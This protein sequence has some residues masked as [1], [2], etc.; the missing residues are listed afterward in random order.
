MG[1]IH[2]E[3]NINTSCK[4]D[5]IFN[6]LCGLYWARHNMPPPPASSDFN[7]HAEPSACMSPCMSLMCIIVLDLYTKFEVCR[8]SHSKDIADFWS[9]H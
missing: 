5:V 1:L 8:P 3:P 4:M 7:S 6:K 2:I 9:Q